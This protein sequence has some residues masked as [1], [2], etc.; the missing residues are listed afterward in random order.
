MIKFGVEFWPLD[1]EFRDR[2]TLALKTGDRIVFHVIDCLFIPWS[3]I[4]EMKL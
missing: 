3:P 4:L 1:S 2:V